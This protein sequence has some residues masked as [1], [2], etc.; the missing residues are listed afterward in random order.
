MGWR[1][2]H[3]GEGREKPRHSGEAIGARYIQRDSQW[4]HVRLP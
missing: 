1:V 4:H 2:I 3:A